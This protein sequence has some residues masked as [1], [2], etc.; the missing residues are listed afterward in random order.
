MR[1]EYSNH[2]VRTEALATV[3]GTC[4]I[5]QV[6]IQRIGDDRFAEYL[7]RVDISLEGAS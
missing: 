6:V 1:F 7:A 2:R 5:D 4:L 3:E